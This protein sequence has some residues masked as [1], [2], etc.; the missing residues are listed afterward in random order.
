MAVTDKDQHEIEQ[1][2]LADVKAT[3]GPGFEALGRANAV[4]LRQLLTDREIYFR[5][6][7]E[8]TQQAFHDE[9]I[10]TDWPRCPLH[11]R[12]PLWLHEGAWWCEQDRV[13]I[14]RVGHLESTRTST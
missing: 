4:R 9:F 5:E 14:A 6:V 2:L 10:D 12:H 7:I 1:L 8:A 13:L 3:L 11:G